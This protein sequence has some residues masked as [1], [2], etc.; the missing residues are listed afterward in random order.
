[1]EIRPVSQVHVSGVYLILAGILIAHLWAGFKFFPGLEL[2]ALSWKFHYTLRII[3][4]SCAMYVS[5]R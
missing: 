5:N 3:H 2:R 1:M 4:V